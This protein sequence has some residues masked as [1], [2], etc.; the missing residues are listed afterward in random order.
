MAISLGPSG[1]TVFATNPDV[2]WAE[3]TLHPYSV[4]LQVG[5]ATR[6][7]ARDM[8]ELLPHGFTIAGSRETLGCVFSVALSVGLPRLAVSQHLALRSPDFPHS[9]RDAKSCYHPTA[10]SGME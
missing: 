8:R 3:P 5:F 7:V 1:R 2:K 4:L 10:L 9:W 6:S